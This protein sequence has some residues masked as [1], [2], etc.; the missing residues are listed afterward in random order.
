VGATTF[1]PFT[2][3]IGTTRLVQFAVLYAF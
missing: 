2:S 3:E 1:A